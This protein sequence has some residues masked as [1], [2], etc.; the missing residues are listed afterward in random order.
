MAWTSRRIHLTAIMIAVAVAV[1]LLTTLVPYAARYFFT[2]PLEG[3]NRVRGEVFYYLAIGLIP[4]AL[5]LVPFF[6]R[7]LAQ[8]TIT[9]RKRF[10]AKSDFYIRFPTERSTRFRTTFLMALGPFALDMLA[11]VNVEYYFTNLHLS[12]VR[13]SIYV[14][15]LLLLMAAA[16]TVLLPGAWLVRELGLRVLNPK[17]G[18]VAQA[19]ALFDGAL[20]PLSA[21]AL[22]VSFVTTLQSASFSYEVGAFA[23]GVWALR[24]FPPVLVAVSVYRMVVEPRVLPKLVSWSEIQ[25]IPFRSDLDQ[26]LET[27]RKKPESSKS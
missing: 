12:A 5:W 2:P 9:L 27:L 26:T 6:T 21:L 17:R 4:V 7:R 1:T 11:I 18:E 23:L 15:P 3:Y 10:F 13:G 14:S 25:G 20:G 22:M 24:L 19:S 8:M 16:I